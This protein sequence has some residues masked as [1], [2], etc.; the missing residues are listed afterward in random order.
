VP[1]CSSEP[2]NS[3]VLTFEVGKVAGRFGDDSVHEVASKLLPVHCFANA[4]VSRKY[5]G[6]IDLGARQ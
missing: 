3:T 4:L 6:T 2:K 1:S 5:L